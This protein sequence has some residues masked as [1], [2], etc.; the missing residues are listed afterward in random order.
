MSTQPS[1]ARRRLDRLYDRLARQFPLLAPFI[2]WVRQPVMV[3]VRLPLGL[4]L[5]VGGVLSFL[6]ILGVW[7]LPLGLM[8]LAIDF[9]PLQGP[10]AWAILSGW[11]WWEVRRM[12][13]R[14]K[15]AASK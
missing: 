8:L 7:M 14:D 12:R 5:I 9:P 3:V 10:I 13:R 4:I 6:P 15:A 1:K 2:S 11:R